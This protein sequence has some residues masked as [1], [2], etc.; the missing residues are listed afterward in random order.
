MN[1]LT[2]EQIESMA[3]LDQA[4]GKTKHPARRII[5]VDIDHTVAQGEWWHE[6]REA[7]PIQE[8]LDKVNQLYW[9]KNTIIYHT[10]RHPKYYELT[11][12]W[13]IKHGAFFHALEMGK[14][15]ADVYLDDR[16]LNVKDIDVL[17]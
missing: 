3:V 1:D 9:N 8:V 6:D 2:P 14:L 12:A 5:A 4:L 13:L 17:L 7:K 10:A 16:A 15:T 11:K